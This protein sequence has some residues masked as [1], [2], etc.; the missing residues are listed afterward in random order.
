MPVHSSAPRLRD[1][2]D[3]RTIG[4][5]SVPYEFGVLPD[6]FVECL[7][8]FKERSGLTWSGLA[9]VLGVDIKQL[10]R[11]RD[12]TEPCGGAFRSLVRIARWVPGGLDLV[13]GENFLISL[14]EGWSDASSAYPP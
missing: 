7:H 8:L 4:G 13:V 3:G 1:D 12:G 11:W 14:R 6:D 9:E 5:R 2:H 10:L